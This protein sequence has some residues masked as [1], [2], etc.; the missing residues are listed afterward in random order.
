MIKLDLEHRMTTVV[1][2][3]D[4]TTADT[5]AYATTSEGMLQHTT[6]II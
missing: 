6:V 2:Q 4:A 1:K 5:Q 3:G